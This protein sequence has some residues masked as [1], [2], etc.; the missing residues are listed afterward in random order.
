MLLFVETT[1]SEL[2]CLIPTECESPAHSRPCPHARSA[3]I[4]HAD[5]RH[6]RRRS[7]NTTTCAVPVLP[8]TALC[9]P[10]NHVQLG[11]LVPRHGVENTRP[12]TWFEHRCS[13]PQRAPSARPVESRGP[14][15]QD[16]GWFCETVVAPRVLTVSARETQC[17]SLGSTRTRTHVT[18]I[19]R[20]NQVFRSVGDAR[21]FG[22]GFHG[23]T[24]GG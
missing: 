12:V 15:L 8:R 13:R 9:S 19:C 11:Q 6:S 14:L 21:H 5:H 24:S 20:A 3:C 4:L 2:Q 18:F 22:K 1:V 23:I 17:P 10:S 7:L 16:A